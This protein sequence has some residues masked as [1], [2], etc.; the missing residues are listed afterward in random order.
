M[1]AFPHAHLHGN[2]L[3]NLE[4]TA[5]GQLTYACLAGGVA[6]AA[7]LLVHPARSCLLTLA[8]LL[9]GGSGGS[10]RDDSTSTGVHVLLTCAI[11]SVAL[12]VALFD[13]KIMALIGYL[14]AFA[15]C[16]LGLVFPAVTLLRL[17][18]PA[19]SSAAAASSATL[20]CEEQQHHAA[21]DAATAAAA[22]SPINNLMYSGSTPMGDGSSHG[23]RAL[24]ERLMPTSRLGDCSDLSFS[25]HGPRRR[26]RARCGGGGGGGGCCG[27]H[28]VATVLAC[29]WLVMV[30]TA[31]LVVELANIVTTASIRSNS[32][33]VASTVV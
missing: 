12:T 5:L 16:P 33:G 29:V 28:G 21:S 13:D 3:I 31:T 18:P 30:A 19:A 4:A 17:P 11:V 15:I 10:G 6:L 24:A 26:H 8:S 32:T 27:G 7:P 25:R 22:E 2:I 23:A 1:L 20:S 9:R 14:G